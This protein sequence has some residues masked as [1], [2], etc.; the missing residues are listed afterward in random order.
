M[1]NAKYEVLEFRA[2]VKPDWSELY[3]LCGPTSDGTLG[4]Q[5]WHKKI[6]SKDEPVLPYLSKALLNQE[7]LIGWDI[8]SPN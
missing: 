8:G 3:V 5:G 2:V 7:Y 1:A 6:I 4:V